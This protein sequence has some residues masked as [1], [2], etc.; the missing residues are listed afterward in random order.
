M[1]N[2]AEI[3]TRLKSYE[4]LWNGWFYNDKLYGSGG[5]GCVLGLSREKESSVVKIIYIEDNQLKYNAVKDEIETMATLRSEYLVECLDYRIEEVFNR[6]GEKIGY[7][8]LIHMNE[9]EPFSEFL[10]EEEYDPNAICLQ[11]AKEIGGALCVLHSNGILH[12]DIKPEN[13]F[14]DNSNGERHFRLG[15]F[16]VSKRIGDMSGLTTTGTLN[17]M[18]PESFKYYEYSYRSDIYN[19]GMTL[20]YILNDL[21]FP[22]FAEEESQSDF[23][24]NTD[25]RLHGEKLPQPIYG[26]SALVKVVIKSCEANPKDRY[27]DI[28]EMLNGLFGQN[29][30]KMGVKLQNDSG[31]LPRRKAKHKKM[32]RIA[33]IITLAALVVSF[34]IYRVFIFQ[35]ESVNNGLLKYN[36]TDISYTLTE[37][38]ERAETSFRTIQKT[39]N[40]SYNFNLDISQNGLIMHMSDKSLNPNDSNT[41]EYDCYFFSVFTDAFSGNFEELCYIYS[42]QGDSSYRIFI[43]NEDIV[44]VVIGGKNIM[45]YNYGDKRITKE[46]YDIIAKVNE[47]YSVIDKNDLDKYRDI[48]TESY[49]IN[50]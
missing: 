10:R 47:C 43:N 3:I 5:S 13:I 21:R 7:D 45:T 39:D 4:P 27:K 46:Y 33:L 1:K 28:S 48:Y 30:P 9:Y 40:D 16:G 31:S 8:F 18:A 38:P 2:E 37:T 15:D 22:V 41:Y 17:F 29:I 49:G 36:L 23:D 6:K 25:C 24:Y 20:Y 14:I 26:S 42:E 44:C 19:L 34:A 32:I 35:N 50:Q 12:R 11:L